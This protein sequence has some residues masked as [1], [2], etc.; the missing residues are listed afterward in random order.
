MNEKLQTVIKS[1]NENGTWDNMYV[2]IACDHDGQMYAICDGWSDVTKFVNAVKGIL[3]FDADADVDDNEVERELEI[4]FVFSDEYVTC[5]DC[6]HVI[7]ISPSYYGHKPDY[8][9]GDG[10]VVC[11]ECFRGESD[12]Q[13]DYLQERINNPKNAINGL[14][15]SDNLVELGFTKLNEDSY[16]SGHHYGQTDDPEEIYNEL[17]DKYDEVVFFI[18]DVGQFD[19]HFDV[20]V[21]GE[22][23]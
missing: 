21:R 1:F 15:T 12:Y 5:S 19:I 3:G 2:D 18:S 23:A 10:F 22:V 14:I 4:E 9:F 13:E 17:S 6:N 11:G 7:C 20:Y 16:E 8:Y